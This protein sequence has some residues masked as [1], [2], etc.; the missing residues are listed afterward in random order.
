MRDR[1]SITAAGVVIARAALDRPSSPEGDVDAERRLAA[2]LVI[3]IGGPPRPDRPDRR[4]FMR[5]VGVRTRFV[6]RA[7]VDAI[8]AGITQIVI[9]GAGYDTRALR[10]RTP[11]MRF[12]EVDHPA[13]Q[14]D[15]RERL[16]DIDARTD[17][18]T[19]VAADFTQPGLDDR[20]FAAG[21]A[22]DTPTLFVCEGVFRYLP[23]E[24]FR[25]LLRVTAAIA[26]PGSVFAATISTREDGVR[27]TTLDAIGEA[28]LTVPPRAVALDW[29]AEAGWTVADADAGDVADEAPGTRRGRLLVRATVGH[30]A[31]R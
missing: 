3:D 2:A 8:T 25:E 1:P 12:F 24:W 21:Y 28:V 9:L 23:E 11:G 27:D 10:F 15:K 6:D 5:Y 31:G 30:P 19:F 26:A 4:D 16:S 29:V 18:V 7:V 22:R 13:T 17:D 14:K 20:L